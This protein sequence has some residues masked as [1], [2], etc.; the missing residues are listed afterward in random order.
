MTL[1]GGRR[2]LS[3]VS[4]KGYPF[5][6]VYAPEGQGFVA[7]EPMTARTDALSHDSAPVVEPGGRFTAR[8]AV[9]L[10]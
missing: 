10:T 2:R 8:F 9:S 6:Q 1:T 7:L 4:D 5:A 3:I